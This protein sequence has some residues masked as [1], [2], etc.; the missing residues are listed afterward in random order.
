[1][2]VFADLSLSDRRHMRPT[3]GHQTHSASY[4]PAFSSCETERITKPGRASSSMVG[5][6]LSQTVTELFVFWAAKGKTIGK[7]PL[8]P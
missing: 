1:M 4:L 5:S 8:S 6:A 7:D 2:T 3:R